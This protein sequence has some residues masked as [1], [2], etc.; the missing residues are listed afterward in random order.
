MSIAAIIPHYN[1][2]DLLRELL[3]QLPQQTRPF[4][5]IIVVDNGSTDGSADLAEQAGAH[6]IRLPHNQGFAAAVNQGIAAAAGF[7]WIAI[8]NN[9][10]TL[11]PTWLSELLRAAAESNASFATG[12]ILSANNPAMLDGAWDE[13]SRGACAVRIGAAAPDAPSWNCSRPIRMASMTAA[14]FRRELF[15]ELGPLDEYLISYLEDV[16]FGLR[17]AKASKTGV[18]APTA[19]AHHQ[20]SATWGKWHPNTVRLLARNQVLLAIKHFRGQPV[21]PIVAGQLLW[22]FLALRHGCAWSWFR[23]KLAGWKARSEMPIDSYNAAAFA[24]ILRASEAELLRSCGD[25][26]YWRL[27]AWLTPLR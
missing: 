21:W 5:R 13:I 20:G 3:T 1:R 26:T 23:G 7:D 12:K 25:Q 11:D 15:D 27:Y 6:V 4:D 19:L 8:L 2:A 10:V 16:D 24:E 18:Y 14:L 22:G 9:D 17:C